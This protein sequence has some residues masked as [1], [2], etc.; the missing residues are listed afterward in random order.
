MV[1]L[2]MVGLLMLVST[3]PNASDT[4]LRG[5]TQNI[6]EFTVKAKENSI[7]TVE[8]KREHVENH[9]LSEIKNEEDEMIRPV[10]AVQGTSTFTCDGDRTQI[11]MSHVDD[12]YCDCEDGSDEPNTSACSMYA[13]S[14]FE[15]KSAHVELGHQILYASRVEDGVCDCCDGSDEPSS[16]CPHRCDEALPPPSSKR[17]GRDRTKRGKLTRKR[18]KIKLFSARRR[19]P[20]GG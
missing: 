15:C 1:L 13:D 4:K 10:P 6:G 16:R 20:V 2:P 12:N 3:L 17:S 18:S 5:R 9:V 7:I 14:R 19:G 11:S 8:K